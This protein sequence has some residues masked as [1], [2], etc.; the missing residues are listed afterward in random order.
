MV[1][2]ILIYV[3]IILV[4]IALLIYS[5]NNTTS[6]KE[7]RD[8]TR[9]LFQNLNTEL[10]N[11]NNYYI[12]GTHLNIDGTLSVNYTDT[13]ISEIKI[14]LKDIEGKELLYNVD[15]KLDEKSIR[16]STSEKINEGINLEEL[17]HGNYYI[18]LRIVTVQDNV[19]SYNYY[20]L[21]NTTNYQDDIE[22]Y[23][24]TRSGK[25]NKVIIYTGEYSLDNIITPY[26]KI[27]VEE[28]RLPNNVY[29]VVID[30]GHGGVDSGAISGGY[31]ESIITLDYSLLLKEELEKLGLKVKLV[32]DSDVK[33]DSYGDNGR[34]VIPN[35]VKAKYVF[36]IHL[37]SNAETMK[38]GGVE[39]YA[40]SKMNLNF[41]KLL[42]DNIVNIAKTTYSPNNIHK[43][44]NGI[45]VR[46][47]T[48]EDIKE[49]AEYALQVGYTK[50]DITTNTP[51]LF[52]L[53]ETGGIATNAYIDGRNKNYGVNKY[54]NSNVGVESYLLELGFMNYKN[55]L[56][57]ILSNKK[58]YIEAITSSVKQHLIIE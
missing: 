56:D 28:S 30:P 41:A 55:D 1:K 11:A 36:S 14:V 24:V 4:L 8:L 34:A 40:P 57:N 43:V 6:I 42:A 5:L 47:Y 12:Y 48:D 58:L 32:R 13:N 39:I 17:P 38:K 31:Y 20:M 22:Y 18:L 37:N 23:T 19:Q 9:E 35:T 49:A 3:A 2:Q 50:Y 46:N 29:D 52:M 45:Y 51:Y 10:V 53:R 7:I 27:N 54:Y 21:D 16:F 25:N 33:V 26:M 44:E 15:Y